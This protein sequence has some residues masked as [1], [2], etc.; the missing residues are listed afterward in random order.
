MLLNFYNNSEPVP[1]LEHSIFAVILYS[2]AGILCTFSEQI[3]RTQGIS[4]YCK[5]PGLFR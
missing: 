3:A 5:A 2:I 4:L 1:E